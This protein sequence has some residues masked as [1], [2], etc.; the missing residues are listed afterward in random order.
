M[1]VREGVSERE[2]EIARRGHRLASVGVK[3][4]QQTHVSSKLEGCQRSSCVF[5]DEIASSTPI[6]TA[7]QPLKLTGDLGSETRSRGTL[8]NQDCYFSSFVIHENE[9]PGGGEGESC[10][11]KPDSTGEVLHH[12]RHQFFLHGVEALCRFV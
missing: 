6:F 7:P 11:S 10:A 4:S 2:R 9:S 8:V 5:L 1:N 12:L 3:R